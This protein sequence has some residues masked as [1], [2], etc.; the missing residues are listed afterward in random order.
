M[1]KMNKKEEQLIRDEIDL[2]KIELNLNATA[3]TTKMSL[4]TTLS[5]GLIGAIAGIVPIFISL[6]K[7]WSLLFA[8][9]FTLTM[10][11]LFIYIYRNY[12]KE[13]R[14]IIKNISRNQTKIILL[15]KKIK[16]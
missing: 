2:E 7:K 5:I 6:Q 14:E 9:N 15:Y 10:S 11:I 13:K 1:I 8:L 12:K 4:F 3:I 16:K